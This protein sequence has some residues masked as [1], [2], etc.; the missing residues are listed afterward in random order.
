M[1]DVLFWAAQVVSVAA[2]CCTIGSF[3][4]RNNDKLMLWQGVFGGALWMVHFALL[5]A[6]AACFSDAVFVFRAFAVR[7]MYRRGTRD[8]G[9]LVTVT[10]LTVIAAVL[11]TILSWDGAALMSWVPLWLGRTVGFA[12]VV[13][14][15]VSTL[16]M[17]SRNGAAIRL[18]QMCVVSP[19]WLSNNIFTCSV[20]GTATEIFCI[21][22]VI[23]SLARY[24]L[25]HKGDG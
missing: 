16:A 4:C 17:W 21:V 22:S 23:V 7:R 18:S 11:G 15:I 24:G 14:N 2:A 20:L 5:G 8:R 13:S 10:I 3:Q 25:H 1:E 9:M 19:V 12:M 6:W